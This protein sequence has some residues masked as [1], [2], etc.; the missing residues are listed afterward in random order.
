L[1]TYPKRPGGFSVNIFTL[2][3]TEL[4]L[5]APTHDATQRRKG[6]GYAGC[7]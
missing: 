6:K 4:Q 7:N 5:G 2:T 1:F 3:V